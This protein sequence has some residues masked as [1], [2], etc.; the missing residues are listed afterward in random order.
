MTTYAGVGARKTPPEVLALFTHIAERLEARGW[1]LHSGNAY[2]ADR[3]FQQGTDKRRVFLPWNGYNGGDTH[4]LPFDMA[5]AQSIAQ[6]YHPAW[7]RC[8]NGAQK[9]HAR[10]VAIMLGR[11]LKDPVDC[12]ICWTPNGEVTGGT[13]QA[14]RI[15]I[16]HHIPI[17]N[18]GHGPQVMDE[19]SA[20]VEEQK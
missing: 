11:T 5:K 7:T 16:D 15:A 17:F 19:L 8:S 9:L 18:F 10:N 4:S 20:F 12:V 14:L 3:A 6:R 1:M 2:G 13:G